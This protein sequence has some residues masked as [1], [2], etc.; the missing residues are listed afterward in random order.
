MAARDVPRMDRRA[1]SEG[2]GTLNP[3]PTQALVARLESLG[4]DPK[5]T[6]RDSW[7]SRCPAHGGSR[8][9]L[10]I[11][12]G[13]DDRVLIHCHHAQECPPAEIVALSV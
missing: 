11:K 4:F 6:G 7:E 10:S 12:R 9:N 3:D 13:D 5:A 2:G 8:R 1:D